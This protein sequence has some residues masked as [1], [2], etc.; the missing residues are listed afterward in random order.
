MLLQVTKSLVSSTDVWDN[1]NAE[2]VTRAGRFNV[3]RGTHT[4]THSQKCNS[5]NLHKISRCRMPSIVDALQF[6]KLKCAHFNSILVSFTR[7]ERSIFC[8]KVAKLGLQTF[9]ICYSPR[10]GQ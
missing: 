6:V 9:S 8:I 3:L 7:G 1:K 10:P 4:H 2:R 5:N